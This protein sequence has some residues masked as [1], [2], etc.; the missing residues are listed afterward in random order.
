[1]QQR[2]QRQL[3]QSTLAGRGADGPGVMQATWRVTAEEESTSE[4]GSV[5]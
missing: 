2:Q 5:R 3:P 4:R 1:M